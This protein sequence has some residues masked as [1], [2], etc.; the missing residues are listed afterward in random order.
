MLEK[1]AGKTNLKIDLAGNKEDEDLRIVFNAGAE[2]VT[3]GSIAVTDPE[4][5][6]NGLRSWP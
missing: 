6:M 2:Q 4:L 3:A 1:I 5:F